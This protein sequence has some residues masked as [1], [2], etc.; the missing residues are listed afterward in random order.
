MPCFGQRLGRLHRHA[1]HDAERDDRHMLADALDLGAAD[2]QDE[3][4]VRRAIERVAVKD[5]VLQHDDRI[6]IADRRAQQPLGIGRR[7]R[8]H[9]LQPR[10]MRIPARVALRVLRGDARC[11]AVRAAEH[12]RAAHLAARHIQRLRRRVDDL[13]HRLHGEVERHELDDRLQPVQRRADR[14]AGEAMLGDRRV[15]HPLRA[16]LIQQ[17]LADLVGALVLR[18]LLADQEHACRRAAAPP[19]SHRAAPRAR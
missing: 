4:L 9:H 2:R 17:A 3:V 15:D 7:P 13:V 10:H 6:G 12:D 5:L 19:P 11:R 16:E 8:R 1:D 14:H 18:D